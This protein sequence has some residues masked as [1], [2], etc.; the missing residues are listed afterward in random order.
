MRV[1]ILTFHRA[2]NYGAVLQAYALQ[3][4]IQGIGL[5][6]EIL[7]YRCPA[8][9]RTYRPLYLHERSLKGVLATAA[10]L[11]VRLGRRAKFASFRRRNLP[12]SV[13]LYSPRTV[14][15]A[16]GRYDRYVVGS[17]QV[18]N[19]DLTEA[20]ATYFLDFVGDPCQKVSYAASLGKSGVL[21]RHAD[22]YLEALA[23]F[24]AISVREQDGQEY[25]Q[26]LLSRDVAWVLDPVLLTEPDS[27]EAIA[28]SPGRSAPYIFAYCLHETDM[29]RY[30]EHLHR[31]TG[32]P[33]VYVPE[34]LRTRVAGTRVLSLSPEEFLG[35]IRDADYVV[36]DSFHVVAF[37]IVFRKVFKAQLKSAF[38]E[39]NSRITSLLGRV[40]LEGQIISADDLHSTA[41]P[42]T[43][44]SNA[45]ILLATA[46]RESLLFLKEALRCQGTR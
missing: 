46:R 14:G 31:L 45:E 15:E 19:P 21:E 36:T 39:L 12:V 30:V 9:E 33:V 26:A 25:L 37:S 42:G 5:D 32:L 44:Y 7:D 13:A 41:P 35:W 16:A 17:D 3:R 4:T 23:S 20:D 18:W 38:P 11:P 10:Y 2:L 6:A 28:V 34:S 43:D 40:R 29:Y 27:F 22:T 8:L 24:G 1:A